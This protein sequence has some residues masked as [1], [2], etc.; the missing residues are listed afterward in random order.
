MLL[1]NRNCGYYAS[2]YEAGL[3]LTNIQIRREANAGIGSHAAFFLVI[4]Y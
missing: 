2:I 1:T 3:A 4:G